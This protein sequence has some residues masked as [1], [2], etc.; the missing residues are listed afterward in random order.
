VHHDDDDLLTRIAA[1][2][3]TQRSLPPPT[4]P[5]DIDR[6]ETSLGFR[7]PPFLVSLYTRV[8][9]GGFGPGA[10]V[11]LPGYNAALLWPVD[12]LVRHYHEC[13]PIEADDNTPF[14]PWPI[15]VV[16]MLYWGCFS[17][18][19]IDCID[20]AAPVLLYES[21][22]EEALPDEAWKIDEPSLEAWWHAWLEDRLMQATITWRRQAPQ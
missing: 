2:A 18:A 17:E 5:D 12:Q 11:A 9:N 19:A 4:T 10:A 8:A 15:G 22:V 20:P 1:K 14:A 3:R 21:D 6:A 16:P 13:H 7:L